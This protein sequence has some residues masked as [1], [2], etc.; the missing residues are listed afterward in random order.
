MT[1]FSKLT[2]PYDDG[3]TESQ[4]VLHTVMNEKSK[5]TLSPSELTTL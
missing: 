1:T 4:A 3:M 5:R 2:E